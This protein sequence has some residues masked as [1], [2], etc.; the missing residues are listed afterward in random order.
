MVLIDIGHA[1]KNL[2]CP[3]IHQKQFR[4][5]A[6]QPNDRTSVDAV[7]WV[8][9]TCVK[10]K[11]HQHGFPITINER[12]G[13]FFPS[14]V[15]GISNKNYRKRNGI[16]RDIATQADGRDQSK[17]QAATQSGRAMLTNTLL[18]IA[19]YQEKHVFL[20]CKRTI[21]DEKKTHTKKNQQQQNKQY[22]H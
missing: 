11:N 6:S 4:T 1:T 2:N 20:Y 21:Q 8:G 13:S 17:W 12:D 7:V 5:F 10:K 18:E 15:F 14:S 16:I 3:T 19:Y 22:E 9:V